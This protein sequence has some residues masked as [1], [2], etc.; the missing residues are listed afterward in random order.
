MRLQLK[1]AI[2]ACASV[3]V[4]MP[5]AVRG[6]SHDYGGDS[7]AAP[8]MGNDGRSV[9]YA[10]EVVRLSRS[11]ET[12]E[13]YEADPN[14][15]DPSED[16]RVERLVRE[17]PLPRRFSTRAEAFNVIMHLKFPGYGSWGLQ[18]ERSPGQQ[19]WAVLVFEIPRSGKDRYVAIS[20]DAK[21]W[22][23]IDD[24]VARHDL[25]LRFAA[26]GT[27]TLRYGDLQHRTIFTHAETTRGPS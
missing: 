15:I 11:Y 22:T 12:Y 10:G 23:V 9:R 16:A 8:E 21:R 1:L 13:D 4:T 25:G 24:F 19:D 7:P 20:G 3:I 14:N 5:A 18:T 27:G 17:A 6:G 26:R 2:T